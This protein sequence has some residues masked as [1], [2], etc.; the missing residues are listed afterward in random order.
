MRLV[1]SHK[2]KT[3]RGGIRTPN[4]NSPT[5]L[6]TTLT[7]G[8]S[9]PVLRR[10]QFIV[11]CYKNYGIL[12]QCFDLFRYLYWYHM[13]FFSVRIEAKLIDLQINIIISCVVNYIC[14]VWK[15]IFGWS[16]DWILLIVTNAFHKQFQIEVVDS[17]FMML[18]ECVECECV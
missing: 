8:P 1:V 15:R 10:V 13:L 9:D 17:F 12:M 16:L 6:S 7:N 14:A 3:D 2:N 5:H 18:L 4:Y 11:L